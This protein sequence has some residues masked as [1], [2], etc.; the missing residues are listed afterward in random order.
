MTVVYRGSDIQ[1]DEDR[2][3][4]FVWSCREDIYIHRD[5][6]TFCVDINDYVRDGNSYYSEV[7]DDD[8]YYRDGLI[9][10]EH[11]YY[12]E[13][14]YVYASHDDEWARYEDVVTFVRLRGYEET[15][16]KETLERYYEYEYNEAENVY[17]EK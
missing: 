11:K 10:A 15:I 2:L 7:L 12:E 3:D 13:N 17:V 1:C 16:L 8:Y 14:G 9:Q 6:A 5:E 4:D